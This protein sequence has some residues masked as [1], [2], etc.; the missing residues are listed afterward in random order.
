MAENEEKLE[1]FEIVEEEREKPDI[2]QV[3]I[4][5]DKDDLGRTFVTE[6][7]LREFHISIPPYKLVLEDGQRI[8]EIKA[9]EAIYIIEH[10][11]NTS[12]PYHFQF[13]TFDF[14]NELN[15]TYQQAK[16]DETPAT[17]EIVIYRDVEDSGRAFVTK[18]VLDRFELPE[19][20][21]RISLGEET[22]YEITTSQAINIIEN[23]TNEYAPYSIKYTSIQ[24]QKPVLG[25]TDSFIEEDDK[26][27]GT[28]YQKPRERR[29]EESEE[30]YVSYLEGYYDSLFKSEE[31]EPKEVVYEKPR[32]RGIYETDEEY[33]AYL[34]Q[35]YS[36]IFPNKEEEKVEDSAVPRPRKAGESNEDYAEYLV[37]FYAQ[38][39]KEQ[40]S[41][42]K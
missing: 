26:I 20:Y 28:S 31:E 3:V 13:Q 17:T 5:R 33:T 14:E 42:T 21:T 19:P 35:H 6:E 39:M 10:A 34:E 29:P 25:E 23:S 40:M 4:Y 24:F 15:D 30:H 38:P 18:E 12:N 11:N 22:I 9:Q 8:Y 27:P 37:L 1:E 7:V 32:P 2:D 41:Y 36:K 16:K